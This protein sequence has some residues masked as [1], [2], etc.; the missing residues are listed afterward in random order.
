MA[1]QATLFNNHM[2]QNAYCRNLKWT[3]AAMLLLRNKDQN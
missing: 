3:I 2:L 1:N